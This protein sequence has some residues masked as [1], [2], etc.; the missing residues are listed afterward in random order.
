[1]PYLVGDERMIEITEEMKE[2]YH[3]GIYIISNSD[4]T[5]IRDMYKDQKGSRLSKE[6][7]EILSRRGSRIQGQEVPRHERDRFDME[8]RDRQSG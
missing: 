8:I 5:M 1:M 3:R 2:R 4:Y 6:G 7:E